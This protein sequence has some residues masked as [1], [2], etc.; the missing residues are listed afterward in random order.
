MSTEH[1]LVIL[2]DQFMNFE[3]VFDIKNIDEHFLL[4]NLKFIMFL[5]HT[6]YSL[7]E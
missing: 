4:K 3:L 2:S 7:A 6:N 5:F 1:D